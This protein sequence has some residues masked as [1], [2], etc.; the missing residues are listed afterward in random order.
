MLVA[1]FVVGMIPLFARAETGI[2]EKGEFTYTLSSDPDTGTYPPEFGTIA[3][4]GRIWTDKSVAVNDDHFDVN[5]KVLAQEYISTYGTSVTS[6]IAAD[7]VMVLDFTTSMLQDTN[8]IPKE[9][10]DGT[11]TMVTRFQALIDAFNQ[12]VDI[13][14]NTNDNNRISVYAFSGGGTNSTFNCINIMPLGHYT[15]TSDSEDPL[16]KY[17]HVTRAYNGYRCDSSTG[18]L[19]DG[20]SFSFNQQCNNGTDTQY[21]I[22][23]G[24]NGL[25]TNINNETDNSI[26][27]KPYVILMTDGGPSTVDYDWYDSPGNLKGNDKTIS[28]NPDNAAPE[29]F[30]P[31]IAPIILT[32]AL[33]RDNLE[34][35]YDAYNGKSLGVEW[36]NIGLGVSEGMNPTGCLVNPAYLTEVTANRNGTPAEQIKYDLEE[37]A[38][39]YTAKDYAANENYVYPNRGNGYVTFA[40]T[41]EVLNDAFVT[42]ANIISLGSQNYTIPIVNHEGSGETTSDVVFTDVIGEG[43]Y[44]TDIILKQNGK[45]PIYGDDSDGDGVYAFNGY[46]TTVTKN[47]DANGQQTLVWSLPAREVAMFTFKDRENITN[48]EYVAA[49]PTTLTYGVDFTNEIEEGPAYT[50]A[51]DSNMVPLTTVTYEIPGDNDY[52]FNVVKDELHNFVS[53]TM[54]TGLDGYTQKTD[55]VTSTAPDSHS[56]AYTAVNDGTADSSAT[57]NGLLGNNG[58]VTFLSRKENIEITVEKIWKDKN[59]TTVTDTSGLPAVTVTLYRMADDSNVEETAQVAQLSNANDYT[60]TYTVPI[61]DP[62]NKRYTYYIRE[63]CPDGY[64]IADISDSLR[65]QDGTLS[66]TN[67]ALPDEGT[68]VVRKQWQNK[69]GGAIT[70]M[71]SLPPVEI[72]LKRHVKILTPVTHTV[73]ISLSDNQ[74]TSFPSGATRSV[75]VPEGSVISFTLRVY[76]V[77][78]GNT[79]ASNNANNARI[80]LNNTELTNTE[81]NSTG[82]DY[83]YS[84]SS[85]ISYANS[86]ITLGGT[87]QYKEVAQTFTVGEEDLTLNYVVNGRG[88]NSNQYVGRT[89]NADNYQYVYPYMVREWDVTQPQNPNVTESTGEDELYQTVTLSNNNQWQNIFDNVPL[90]ENGENGVVYSYKYFVEEIE[91]PGFEAIYSDNNTAGIDGGIITVTN[92]STTAIG[93]LPETG[94]RSSPQTIRIVGFSIAFLSMALFL[95]RMYLPVYKKRRKSLN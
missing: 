60:Q 90:T 7:V 32:A 38:A 43:M 27:R 6:S 48:G 21:G 16:D 9:N 59:G 46:A 53:S 13:I 8:K 5:L 94:G 44:V 15:S 3:N 12:A 83:P 22:A 23:N 55:N 73:T 65:A 49:D 33:W 61:R 41:Y 30:I 56:Y 62:D 81:R 87:Q 4:N 51:F 29:D 77:R 10:P 47:E 86:A 40:D 35:A 82:R 18:L 52:Y 25:I 75:E 31:F 28:G 45:P 19:K 71:S 42:L 58:K 26:A 89:G 67:R 72:K 69:L 54:K 84:S 70:D 39:N 80:F 92:R 50:N 79:S 14:T 64:F 76:F 93:P 34:A 63:N 85:G 78:T 68:V 1:A 20:E 91:V 11:T 88:V 37:K 36:F 57:V 24:I 66:V 2:A 17:V 95:F 74:N